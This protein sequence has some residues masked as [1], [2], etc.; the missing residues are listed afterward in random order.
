MKKRRK[1]RKEERKRQVKDKLEQL[2]GKGI[3]DETKIIGVDPGKKTIVHMTNEI[4]PKKGDERERKTLT[5][6]SSQRRFESG[7][8]HRKKKLKE[9]KSKE[10]MEIESGLSKTN[11]K[12][13]SSEEFKEYLSARFRVQNDL[14]NYYVDNKFRIY[15]WLNWRFRRKSEDLFINQIGKT[16]GEN[17]ILAYGNWSGSKKLKG[18]APS[19]TTGIRRRI[20]QQYNVVVITEFRTSKTCSRCKGEL[21]EDSSRFKVYTKKNSEGKEQKKKYNLWSIRRCYNECGGSLRLFYYIL[22]HNRLEP[23]S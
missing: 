21:K 18:L 20:G 10:V 5:Y 15:R 23:R 8:A 22:V 11:S 3:E 17:I 19:P 1:E 6:T 2:K 9:S 7:E 14:Y 16:F 4:S 12:N 13:P